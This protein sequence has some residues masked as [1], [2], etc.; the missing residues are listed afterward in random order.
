MQHKDTSQQAF[1]IIYLMCILSFIYFSLGR[2]RG[3]FSQTKINVRLRSPNGRFCIWFRNSSASSCLS[4]H[5]SCLCHLTLLV[6][7]TS[8]FLSVSPHSSCLCHLTLLVCH[9][10]LLVCVTSLFLSVTSLFLSVSPHSSCL[11]PHS[12]C[13]CHLTLLVCVSSLFLSDISL[14]M[15]NEI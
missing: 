15:I 13:L 5:S 11:S 7:V 9:L 12:S 4:P 3:V 6:C 8:L 14:H 10:T 1:L 2:S